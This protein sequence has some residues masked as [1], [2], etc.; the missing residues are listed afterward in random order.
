MREAEYKKKLVDY[1]KKNLKKEY[2]QESLRWAL[3]KQGYSKTLVDEAIRE[4]IKDL[5]KEAAFPKEKPVIT[6]ELIGENDQPISLERPWWKKLLGM[7]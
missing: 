5:S 3:V 6:H 4:A 1:L 7:D 2:S